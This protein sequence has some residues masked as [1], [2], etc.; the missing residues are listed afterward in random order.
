[1]IQGA[2]RLEGRFFAFYGSFLLRQETKKTPGLLAERLNFVVDGRGYSP[3]PPPVIGS[4]LSPSP[5]PPPSTSS[6]ASFSPEGRDSG[7]APPQPTKATAYTTAVHVTISF[8]IILRNRFSGTAAVPD[9]LGPKNEIDK[10]KN[11]KI[12]LFLAVFAIPC[13]LSGRHRPTVMLW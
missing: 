1:M 8:F 10:P 7:S 11:G 13:R 2:P 5:S 3:S 4:A 9:L 6:P 12:R